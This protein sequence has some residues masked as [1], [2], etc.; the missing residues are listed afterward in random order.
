MLAAFLLEPKAQKKE[1]EARKLAA[2]RF[3]SLPKENAEKDVRRLWT[4]TNAHALDQC[5]LL[6]KAGENFCQIDGADT[7]V[8]NLKPTKSVDLMGFFLI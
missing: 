1:L 2:N 3:A 7:I 6:K 4:A 5:R 8:N